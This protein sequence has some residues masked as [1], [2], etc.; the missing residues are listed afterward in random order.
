MAEIKY[1]GPRRFTGAQ[2]HFHSGS[3]HTVDGK[4]YELEMHTVHLPLASKNGM[5]YAALGILF[6]PTDYTKEGVTDEMVKTIDTFFD[7][8]QW[9]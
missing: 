9:T 7:S 2:F 6:S 8:L 1:G 4:R 3:E 5:K